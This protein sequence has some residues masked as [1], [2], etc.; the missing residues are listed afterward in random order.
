[1][2]KCFECGEP[3]HANHHVVPKALGGTQTIPLC[4]KCH[5]KVHGKNLIHLA[6]LKEDKLKE[7]AQQ[8]QPPA[9]G[10]PPGY[11]R[12]GKSHQRQTVIDEENK[13]VPIKLFD[14]CLNGQTTRQ[15]STYFNTTEWPL[16]PATV[17][18]LL[19]NKLYIGEIIYGSTSVLNSN[20]CIIDRDTFLKAQQ[21]LDERKPAIHKN[22]SYPKGRSRWRSIKPKSA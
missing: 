17:S 4:N 15:M 16:S 6:K 12:I 7:M 5:S 21:S 9:G 2:D 20:L 22:G 10:L 3:A 13:W 11:K 14:L 8:G 1:M 18:N 19:R